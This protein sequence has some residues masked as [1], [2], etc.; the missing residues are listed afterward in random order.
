MSIWLPSE[1]NQPK[2]LGKLV[3]DGN[4]ANVSNFI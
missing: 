1:G 2:R 4:P 3:T